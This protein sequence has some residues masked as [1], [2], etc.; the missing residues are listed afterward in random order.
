MPNDYALAKELGAVMDSSSSPLFTA[1]VFG[2][3]PIL[4]GL[5]IP[6]GYDWNQTNDL[7]QSGLYL[8][9]AAGHK[10]IVQDLLQHEVNVNTFGG[11]LDLALHAACFGGHANI[12]KLLLDHNA[13]PKLE[14]RSALEYAIL[15]GH[16]K[17]A[18][19]LLDSKFDISDQ[20][21]FDSVLQQAA[22]AGFAE[23]LQ[24]LQKRYASLYGE[25]GSSRCRAVQVAM[26]IGRMAVV[27]RDICKSWPTW[28][29]TWQR[30]LSQ[31][32][33]LAGRMP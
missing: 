10:K 13:N 2:L 18:L 33:L 27:E 7:G 22:E 8:A 5:A 14:G 28:E 23:V 29:R 3:N 11:R 21:E 26:F 12:V 6:T 24:F 4:D 19:L 9:A 31:Q 32:P 16:E 25:L 20:V 1:C 30:M 17:I 15:A